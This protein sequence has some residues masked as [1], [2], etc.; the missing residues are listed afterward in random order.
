VNT[1]IYSLALGFSMTTRVLAGLAVAVL[2]VLAGCS[3][4]VDGTVTP[5]DTTSAAGTSTDS[6]AYSLSVVSQT[7][8]AD[9]SGVSLYLSDEEHAIEEFAALNVTISQVGFKQAGGGWVERDV[10]GRTADLTQLR[11]PNATRLTTVQPP[12]GSYERVFIY[13]STVN[14]TLKNGESVTVKLPS[15]KLHVNKPFTA[16]PNSSINYVFDISVHAAGNSGKYILKPVVGQS[17]TDVPLRDVNVTAGT[18]LNVS[19]V[20]AA[21]PGGDATFA[22]Q[23]N[24]SAVENATVAVNGESV[25]QTD[26]DGRITVAMPESGPVTMTVSADG[27]TTEL[28]LLT[29]AADSAGTATAAP[30]ETVDNT[31]TATNTSTGTSVNTTT[32]PAVTTTTT[33]T[34]TTTTTASSTNATTETTTAGSAY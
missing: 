7:T 11:G 6:A 14:G 29:A 1:Y 23:R 19:L 22:V 33:A 5:I 24:D 32:E 31:A 20:S 3:G 34:V 28:R 17:G 25:G 16:G 12:N 9:G 10:D 4:P 26:A 21:G 15:Q 8:A 2:V 18:A 30:T 27:V 13:V